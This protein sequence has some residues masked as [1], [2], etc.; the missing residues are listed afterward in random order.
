MPDSFYGEGYTFC[1]TE[2]ATPFGT[3]D[4]ALLF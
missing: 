3:A 2:G 4:G 1:T